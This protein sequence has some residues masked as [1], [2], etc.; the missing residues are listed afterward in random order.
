MATLRLSHCPLLPQ[1]HKASRFTTICHTMN[2]DIPET[3]EVTQI[4]TPLARLVKE[5]T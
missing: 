1:R 2:D 3:T 5:P 4:K